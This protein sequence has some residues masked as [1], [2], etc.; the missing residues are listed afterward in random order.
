LVN[1]T[2]CNCSKPANA[3]GLGISVYDDSIA[4]ENGSVDDNKRGLWAFYPMSS[5]AKVPFDKGYYAELKVKKF[6]EFWLSDG[7]I[8]GNHALPVKLMNLVVRK[9]GRNDAL[10]SWTVESESMVDHY[11]IEVARENGGGQRNGFEKIGQVA[12]RDETAQ[13][14]QYEFTDRVFPKSGIRHYRLKIVDKDGAFTYSNVQSLRFPDTK[15]W[16]VYPNPSADG[17]F[18]FIYQIETGAE[19]TVQLR[20]AIGRLV[21]TF[22]IRGSGY[23]E[24]LVVD[25]S[26]G[27]YA[28]G[29]YMLKVKSGGREQV[30]KLYK[31]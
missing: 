16:V 17:R 14:Q 6:S 20:D 29:I 24:K 25:L 10:V 27:S 12:S 7:G 2:G 5:V 18:Y 19:A 22:E 4:Y 11:E 21:K 30:F 23:A 13:Q 15:E 31:Q 28:K 26:A 9:E 8:G 1:A 3:Y